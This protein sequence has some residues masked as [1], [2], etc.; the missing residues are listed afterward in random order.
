MTMIIGLMLTLH[1]LHAQSL[2]PRLYSNA[3]TGTN[4]LLLGYSYSD[5]GVTSVTRLENADIAMHCMV[6][7]YA[8]FIDIAGDSGKVDLVVPA[9]NLKGRAQIEGQPIAGEINGL[10]DIKARI[11]W[12]LYGA[13]ALPP[14][15][16]GSY[17]QDLIIGTSLQ[18]TAPTGRYAYNRLLNTGAN[19]WAFKPGIGLSKRWAALS[20]NSPP[21]RNSIPATASISAAR[22]IGRSPSTPPRHT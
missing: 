17:T 19:R 14:K 9:C 10:G 22:S 18:L 13:P 15:A 6:S 11:S 4:F 2:E 21:M 20:S 16:Y 1:S 5:G 7:A 8:R 3:P 12:N